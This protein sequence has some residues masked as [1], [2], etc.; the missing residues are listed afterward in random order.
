MDDAAEYDEIGDRRALVDDIV[1]LE[2]AS[3]HDYGEAAAA[4]VSHRTD[5]RPMRDP[6]LAAS[7]RMA[8]HPVQ[9]VVSPRQE[10]KH[11]FLQ[12]STEMI[13]DNID[14]RIPREAEEAWASLPDSG[15]TPDAYPTPRPAP[16]VAN[17][18]STNDD[19]RLVHVAWAGETLPLCRDDATAT[20]IL[21]RSTFDHAGPTHDGAVAVQVE[22]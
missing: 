13:Y 16:I 15:L 3:A 9:R 21:V 14:P 19:D 17:P 22:S 2:L 12:R 5:A 4:D 7:A 1:L 6:E 18:R 11:S 8:P 20:T 10:M